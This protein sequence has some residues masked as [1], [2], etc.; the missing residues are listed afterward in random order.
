MS[1]CAAPNTTEL[2]IYTRRGS[3]LDIIPQIW[4]KEI[5]KQSETPCYWTFFASD[6]FMS[7]P[8]KQKKGSGAVWKH[9]NKPDRVKSVL[10]IEDY[11]LWGSSA[12]YFGKGLQVS[13]SAGKRVLQYEDY[14]KLI[15]DTMPDYAVIPVDPTLFGRLGSKREETASVIMKKLREGIKVT[16]HTGTKLILSVDGFSKGWLQGIENNNLTSTGQALRSDFAEALA[17]ADGFASAR[18]ST[19]NNGPIHD[20]LEHIEGKGMNPK[21]RLLYIGPTLQVSDMVNAAASGRYHFVECYMAETVTNGG[22]AIIND[23]EA[24]KGLDAIITVDSTKV[25]YPQAPQS[26][27]M[28]CLWDTRF[29]DDTAATV[30]S[31]T[32]YCC[33]NHSRAYLHH[34]LITHEML[35]KTLLNI[36][37]HHAMQDL[38]VRSCARLPAARTNN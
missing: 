26:L 1:T 12:A 13:T 28:L 31:C 36:H 22:Y 24:N 11:M 4:E 35:A 8:Y 33:R 18:W 20:A 7:L 16:K 21:D 23:E 19:A 14:F 17:T 2:V 38:L 9:F 15:R 10:R 3:P 25:K 32:C 6:I 5:M 27:R 29:V 37:N 30:P 34:L